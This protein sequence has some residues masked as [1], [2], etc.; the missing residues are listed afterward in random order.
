M[1]FVY[2]FG[3]S[4]VIAALEAYRQRYP[5]QRFADLHGF[6]RVDQCPQQKGS[7]PSV[8][9][10]VERQVPRTMEEK[11]NIIDLLQRS[12]RTRTR[13]SAS[14]LFPRVRVWKTLHKADCILT[15]S[16]T[17][18]LSNVRS[19]VTG[20]NSVVELVLTPCDS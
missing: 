4:D 3:D 7:L 13:R 12:P 6:S 18:S 1:H 15:I 19:W 2:G 11:E 16:S 9:G 14:L 20:W 10:R 5:E 8:N 17:L